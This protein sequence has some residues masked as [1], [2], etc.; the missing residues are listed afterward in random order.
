MT[1]GGWASAAVAL[2]S[3]SLV[4]LVTAAQAG[5]RAS[6]SQGTTMNG[7]LLVSVPLGVVTVT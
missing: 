6:W 1:C 5:N 3:S 7:L 2:V 4:E